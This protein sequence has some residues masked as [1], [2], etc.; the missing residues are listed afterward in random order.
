M[1][2]RRRGRLDVGGLFS[3]MVG[4]MTESGISSNMTYPGFETGKRL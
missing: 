4:K 3:D 1:S 2:E